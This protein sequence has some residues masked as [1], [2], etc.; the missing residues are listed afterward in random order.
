LKLTLIEKQRITERKPSVDF[1]VFEQ[2]SLFQKFFIILIFTLLAKNGEIDGNLKNIHG[3]EH[4]L[5][6]ASTA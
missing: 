6:S 1:Y 5:Y 3:T 4:A 2:N